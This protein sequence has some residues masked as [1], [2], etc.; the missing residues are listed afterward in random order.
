MRR[1]TRQKLTQVVLYAVLV[2][3]IVFLAVSTDWEA[4][5]SNFFDTKIAK[6][7]WPEIITV[8]AK[9]TIVYTVIAFLGGL[10]LAVGLALM[11]LS[12]VAPYR[13]LATAYIEFFRG[14]PALVVII[15][16][17]LAVPLVLGRPLPFG[18][19]G[20]GVIALIV[21]SAAYMAETLRAG[22]QAVPKGQVEAARSLGMSSTR[23]MTFIVIPQALRTVLPPLTNE[24][25]LLTKDSS[26]A[27]LLG[28]TLDQYELA[29]FGR[30][31]LN[32]VRSMTP[33]LLVGLCYLVITIPLSLLAR[34]LERRYGSV[35]MP[36]GAEV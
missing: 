32:Q 1:S 28:T 23:T 19:I 21:V 24:L 25:I 10:V 3:V 5:R 14:L 34:R 29:Q 33:L 15:A 17:A 7:L 9:N 13:W 26:L 31:A 22:I 35:G 2:A 30:A 12:T 6:E 4:V 16:F 8:A 20:A 27:F 18:T 11:R 36:K